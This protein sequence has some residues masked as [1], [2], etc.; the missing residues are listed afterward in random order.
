[1]FLVA[2]SSKNILSL[3]AAFFPY[4][5]SLNLV[6]GSSFLGIFF[7]SSWALGGFEF[8]LI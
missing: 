3:L 8:C 6:G 7:L 4:V 2:L 5:A 1:M